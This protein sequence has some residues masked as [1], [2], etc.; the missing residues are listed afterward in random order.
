MAGLSLQA[1][2]RGQGVALSSSSGMCT[3]QC[4]RRWQ[5]H[6]SWLASLP[7]IGAG[8]EA[9]IQLGVLAH[10]DCMAA[11]WGQQRDRSRGV[12]KFADGHNS[13]RASRRHSSS[14]ASRPAAW[15]PDPARHTAGGRLAFRV[16]RHQGPV[17][18]GAVTRHALAD[19]PPPALEPHAVLHLRRQSGGYSQHGTCRKFNLLQLTLEVSTR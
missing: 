19:G 15:Q 2:R 13:S 4:K 16:G 11:A 1:Q 17:A 7:T 8:G 12:D 5:G 9:R 10:H 6:A 18:P 3:A 14:G